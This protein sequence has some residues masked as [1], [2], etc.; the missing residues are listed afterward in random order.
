MHPKQEFYLW[1]NWAKNNFLQPF[2]FPIHESNALC[3][4]LIIL[5]CVLRARFLHQVTLLTVAIYF[6]VKKGPKYEDG[7]VWRGAS[8]RTNPVDRDGNIT[9]CLICKSECHYADTCPHR[10]GQQQ[11]N[12]NPTLHLTDQDNEESSLLTEE[13]IFLASEEQTDKTMENTEEK[14]P[15][16]EHEIEEA[17][18]DS[19]EKSDIPSLREQE[20]GLRNEND[21]KN[22]EEEF[23]GFNSN[24]KLYLCDED[25]ESK[26]NEEVV[27]LEAECKE[28]E[29]NEGEE[30]RKLGELLTET[31]NAAILDTG[32][33][34][35]V[36][37]D[38]WVDNYI[39]CLSEEEKS[40]VEFKE[41]DTAYRFGD[42]NKVVAK[43]SVKLPAKIGRLSLWITTDIVD[44]NIPLLLSRQ[45][46]KKG[47]MKLDFE[48]DRG[49]LFGEEISLKTTSKGH[50]ILP[51]TNQLEFFHRFEKG[52][53]ESFNL[54]ATKCDNNH[55]TAV[56]LHKV[57]AHPSEKRLVNLIDSAGKKWSDNTNLKE[58]IRK[59]SQNCQI[60][61]RFKR[62]CPRPVVGLSMA[63]KFN[64]CVAM[65]LKFYKG[66]IL[67][68]MI[69]HASRLSSGSRISS[70]DPGVII[71]SI[72][73]NWITIYGRPNKFLSDNGGEFMNHQFIDL[74]E[75]MNISVKNTAGESP[76]SNGL[77]ERHNLVIAEMLDKVLA[78]EACDFDLAL[79]WCLNAK[80]SLMNVN[81]FT[82]YQ[83]AMGQNPI[84]PAAVDNELPGNSLVHTSDLVRENLNSMSAARKAYVETESSRKIKT[85]LSRNIR[86]DASAKFYT[87]DRVF[88]KR[89]SS[90]EWKGPG[91]V[92]GQ[93][94][95]KV[96]IKHGP[97]HVSVHP[98]RVTLNKKGQEQTD[99]NERDGEV[100]EDKSEG[101]RSEKE[102]QVQPNEKDSE[103]N[104]KVITVPWSAGRTGETIDPSGD[105]DGECDEET[106]TT[107]VVSQPEE[108]EIPS[109]NRKP[110]KG[111]FVSV[112]VEGLPDK[113]QKVELMSRA[114][115]A[116]G[117]YKD[118]WNVKEC[119]S[120][121][122][123]YVD[124]NRVQWSDKE[125]NE[126]SDHTTVAETTEECLVSNEVTKLHN[127]S[128]DS[129]KMRE[130]SS[131][132]ENEVYTEV[133]DVGQDRITL[134]WVITEKVK[135]S[136]IVVKARLCARGFEE[137]QSFRK[138]SPT[139]SKECVRLMM[140]LTA[141]MKWE[142]NS[143][144]IKTAFLQGRPF[145]REV[146]VKPPKE[147]MSGKLWRLNK[148]IYGLKDAS[149]Q[150]YL[151]LRD[152]VVRNGG[153]VSMHEPGLF[154]TQ[155]KEG[156]MTG[157]MPCHV[158]DLLWAGTNT[159]KKDVVKKIHEKF[160]VGSASSIAFEYIGIEMEQEEDTKSIIISQEAYT[161]SIQYIEI[162]DSRVSDKEARLTSDE[163]TMLR[164][165]VGQLNWLSCVTRPD[166]AFNVSVLSSNIKNA[167]V[168]DLIQA[169]KVIKKVKTEKTFMRFSE[170][171]LDS[172]C[173]MSFSD[174][175]YNNLKNGGSQGGYIIFLVDKYNHCCPLEWKSNRLK[176]V[177]RS[178]LA[179]ETLACAESVEAC[180]HWQN[181]LREI[182]QQDVKV[183]L[184]TDSKSL[185]D[186]LDGNRALSDRLLRVDTNVIRENMESSNMELYHIGGSE[187]ISDIL[188][189]QG[190][191]SKEFLEIFKTGKI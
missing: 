103:I 50:Y 1:T 136:E 32:A 127:E 13:V 115:K 17:R 179:A 181:L 46:M 33:T 156:S 57:F 86:T 163:T 99:N 133:D 129:A 83:V 138:D 93:D 170:L 191:K 8:A 41:S 109:N 172:V 155:N 187:N 64:E 168:N 137:T 178:A 77:V 174:A 142:I 26:D 176:R 186:H 85:A 157:L 65:D 31:W 49:Q 161:N 171:D 40:Q 150:W 125:H 112:N 37:G 164:E 151:T 42:G 27:F 52:Q 177:V 14:L 39:N 122:E 3:M 4:L 149:R 22:T 87:G 154:F 28:I 89:D 79:A 148:C 68:H 143:I 120:G 23:H 107:T 190:V 63:T 135:N 21:T 146:Y 123:Y 175:S 18:K 66:K 25:E 139:C 81:G 189:K 95:S 62:P 152:E 117:K 110:G 97:Y 113:W 60:C 76:W 165:A 7:R 84:L 2:P 67:I 104:E 167:T 6:D 145:D 5:H 160:T 9:K 108:E 185:C 10:D 20:Q 38:A 153:K 101:T 141:S 12:E 44:K 106:S 126:S 80:N 116:T 61:L 91:S 130:L 58:E 47:K 173:I 43:K 70:K 29:N 59:V 34:R 69:D 30:S 15:V 56:K 144:D 82:P 75:K 121:K 98:C 51:L 158:D 102:K 147:A 94:G 134:R 166:I 140:A 55:E 19:A 35:T 54:S 111:E 45:S 53:V 118:A 128:V 90:N 114:G 183:L 11:P 119:E 162:D 105:S 48:R 180:K 188:T 182:M 78:E 132:M 74:C 88:Y 131:W 24:T 100:P 72:F 71:K 73:K 184:H 169:N 92:I 36:S 96:I 16:R 159:F 124:L